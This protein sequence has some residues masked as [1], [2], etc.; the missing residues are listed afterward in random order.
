[1][2]FCNQEKIALLTKIN[3][4]KS[5]VKFPHKARCSSLPKDCLN[6]FSAIVHTDVQNRRS[7]DRSKENKLFRT[8]VNLVFMCKGASYIIV[9]FSFSNLIQ[10]R[11]ITVLDSHIPSINLKFWA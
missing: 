7:R 8:Y 3:H 11:Y 5:S 4:H 2:L 1:M 9:D 6:K 10:N